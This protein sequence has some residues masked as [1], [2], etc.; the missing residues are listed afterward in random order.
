MGAWQTIAQALQS[1]GAAGADLFDRL[2]S[3]VG[4]GA[5]AR[6][7]AFSM[8]VVAL[9]A[10]MAKADGV[11]TMSEAEVF[12]RRFDVAAE[13]RVPVARLFELAQ[14]DVAGF[15]AYAQ[16]I[17]RMFPD[18]PQTR[19]DILD[20]LYTIAAADGVVHERELAFLDRVADI[21]HL[22]GSRVAR[23]KARHLA[24]PSGAD[25]H[26]ILGVAP[27]AAFAEVR[28][29]YLSLVAE[30]H[31]DRLLARGVPDAFVRLANDRLAAINAAYETIR[32]ARAPAN[33]AT[34]PDA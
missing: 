28:A 33:A 34:G 5:A 3:A 27:D 19:E 26:A 8:A 23:V 17:A 20:I 7:A 11:V 12:W 4:S 31:P 10:K 6:E 18:D 24:E 30:H 2:R 9:S 25:P 21:F 13:D 16:R 1:A 15:E 22:E 32:R 29:R 14:R